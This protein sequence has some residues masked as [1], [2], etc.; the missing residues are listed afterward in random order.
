MS[1]EP[2]ASSADAW[3]GPTPRRC[4]RGR[5]TRALRRATKT[6]AT[7]MLVLA[8][9]LRHR[10]GRDHCAPETSLTPRLVGRAQHRPLDRLSKCEAVRDPEWVA[11]NGASSARAAASELVPGARRAMTLTTA[12]AQVL[13]EEGEVRQPETFE[14]LCLHHDTDAPSIRTIS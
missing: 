8:G 3:S 4:S 12:Q 7:G 1:T 9:R 2:Y 13:E 5:P 10:Y 6:S 11:A 14:G